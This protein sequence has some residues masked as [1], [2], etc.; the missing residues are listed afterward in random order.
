MRVNSRLCSA[1]LVLA[2]DAFAR[3]LPAAELPEPLLHLPFNEGAGDGAVDVA[4]DAAPLKFFSRP[5]WAKGKIGRALLS[6]GRQSV[7]LSRSYVGVAGKGTYSCWVKSKAN[8]PQNQEIMGE[9]VGGSNPCWMLLLRERN[10]RIAFFCQKDLK[11]PD[12]QLHVISNRTA[13]GRWTHIAVTFNDQFTKIYVNGALAET[14]NAGGAKQR[15]QRKFYVNGILPWSKGVT[16][17][18]DDV[19]VYAEVLTDAQVRQ[20]YEQS[21]TPAKNAD[22]TAPGATSLYAKD[23]GTFPATGGGATI[24][25]AADEPVRAWLH[26][27]KM[28][29]ERIG[30]KPDDAYKPRWT[31]WNTTFRTEHS[32]RLRG[33]AARTSFAYKVWMSDLSGNVAFTKVQ[34]FQTPKRG[35]LAWVEPGARGDGTEA[36]P[37]SLQWA[38]QNAQPGD[39]IYLKPGLYQRFAKD[40]RR[41]KMFQ[42]SLKGTLE[43]P[44]V[45]RPAPGSLRHS[46]IIDTGVHRTAHYTTI[47]GVEL[48]TTIKRPPD[49]IPAAQQRRLVG[50]ETG[51]HLSGDGVRYINCIIHDFYDCNGFGGAQS[52]AYGNIMYG[53]GK[54]SSDGPSTDGHCWYVQN[55]GKAPTIVE[56]CVMFNNYG[57]PLHIYTGTSAPLLKVHVLGN[58]MFGNSGVIVKGGTAKDIVVNDNIF[59]GCGI[60]PRGVTG[61]TM[62]GNTL[63]YGTVH[64]RNCRNM[65]FTGNAMIG[66]TGRAALEIY[67]PNRDGSSANYT[68]GRNTYCN[69]QFTL[70]YT[71]A[72]AKFHQ[73]SYHPYD[74]REDFARWQ[75]HWDL[76]AEST[77]TRALPKGAKV[78]I[79]KNKYDANR[80]TIV[81][82]NWRRAAALAV[83]LAEGLNDGDGYEIFNVLDLKSTPGAFKGVRPVAVGTYAGRPVRLRQKQIK[84]MGD[85]NTFILFATCAEQREK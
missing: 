39:T 46:V 29:V 22:T 1:F 11:R 76:D 72:R 75:K 56:Q 78:T 17:L 63:V 28:P 33:L 65:A 43:K 34:A 14:G 51:L 82:Y 58:V 24:A 68:I 48:T 8:T 83:D 74:T 52:E 7:T 3:L 42:F 9:G 15:L 18:L 10:G 66:R 41:P 44:I 79:Q 23:V 37:T 35:A 57:F 60:E 73:V 64:P 50:T 59:Y 67:S 85:F 55:A 32:W 62:E 36:H 77:Y 5:A 30:D 84:G 38:A 27:R 12:Q 47:E 61:M 6:N 54:N 45:F 2:L 4:S 53:N 16:G 80:S 13:F 49:G 81:V 31:V 19:R 70:N 71:D 40:D 26:Y 69:I 25:L 21:L 20:L